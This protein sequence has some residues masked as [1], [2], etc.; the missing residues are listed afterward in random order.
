MRYQRFEE[1]PVWND[2]IELA[3]H[4]FRLS[5]AGALHG[6]GDLKNQLERS[7]LS[8]SNNI[9]EG[10]ARGTNDELITFLDYARGSAGEVRSMLHLL[11]RLPEA[12]PWFPDVDDLL[13]RAENISRQLGRWIESLKNSPFKGTRSQNAQTREAARALKRR[14][15]FLAK[16]R[17]IQEEAS[18]LLRPARDEGPFR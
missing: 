14:D 17:A 16:L 10:F 2:A 4:V 3:L 6:F 1:L 9:A 13:R 7:A 15:E 18:R 5:R 12:E 8:I 11:S